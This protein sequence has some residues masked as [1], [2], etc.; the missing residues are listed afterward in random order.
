MRKRRTTAEDDPPGYGGYRD[1]YKS[2]PTRPAA[3]GSARR[4]G[5]VALRFATSGAIAAEIFARVDAKPIRWLGLMPMAIFLLSCA[6]LETPAVTTHQVSEKF[7]QIDPLPSWEDTATKA[8]II[9]FV[10]AV[11]DPDSPGYF[12]PEQRIATFDNDG[13]LWVEQPLYSELAFAIHRIEVLARAHPEWKSVDLLRTLLARNPQSIAALGPR[14]PIEL[15]VASHTGVSTS[16]FDT[17]V[18]QWMRDARH[19][20]LKRPYTHLAYQPQL[21]LLAFLRANDFR[22]YLVCAGTVEFMRPSAEEMYGIHADQIVGTSV[23]TAYEVQGGKASLVRLPWI[24]AIT[25]GDG[26]PVGIQKH[27]GQRPILAFG[28]S[29]GDFEMLQWTTLGSGG[30]RLGLVLHHDDAEREYAYDR[31]SNI[32]RLD[33]IL[34]VADESGWVVVSMKNDWRNIFSEEDP[35]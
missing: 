8:R 16:T 6:T 15:V 2:E 25:D 12:E 31:E 10:R 34:D 9:D 11:T 20:S 4:S 22:T 19:P 7:P 27:I 26:K 30:T 5:A 18:H 21:E 24:N 28:N 1:G 3:K 29:D 13:T 17:I 33:H 32:G 35:Q 23:E 14:V